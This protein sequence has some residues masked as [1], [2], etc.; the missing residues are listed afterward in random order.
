M[1]SP[2]SQRGVNGNTGRPRFS[3]R[4][5]FQPHQDEDEVAEDTQTMDVLSTYDKDRAQRKENLA[6]R[7]SGKI[8]AANRAGRFV[9]PQSIFATQEDAERITDFNTQG[10]QDEERRPQAASRKTSGKRK[11]QADSD[12]SGDEGFE[13]DTRQIDESQNRRNAPQLASPNKRVRIEE[14]TRSASGI[15]RRREE[16]RADDPAVRE[17]AEQKQIMKDQQALPASQRQPRPNLGRVRWSNS[18]EYALEQMITEHGCSWALIKDIDSK[19]DQHF[20]G[21]DQVALKDKAR[22]MKVAYIL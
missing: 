8:R 5:D 20:E 12:V 14:P 1:V 2:S 7:S 17:Y 13:Q 15:A 11:Q 16:G 9:P 21:R 4:D 3:Q 10:T 19:T 6:G 22:N 18:E